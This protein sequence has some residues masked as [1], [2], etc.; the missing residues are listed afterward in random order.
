[1]A[2]LTNSMA[3]SMS[4]DKVRQV[5]LSIADQGFAVGGMF[6][7]SIALARTQTKPEYGI[8]ALTYSIF[9]FIA[10]LHNAAILEAYTI[11]GSGRYKQRFPAYSSLLW[12]RTL[13][14]TFGASLIL[15]IGWM[16]V[17]RFSPLA[18]STTVLG[19]TLTCGILLT[20]LFL[21]RT[22]Y[23]RGRPD[24][25][26]RMSVIF[27]IICA[28]LL[29]FA[30]RNAILSGFYAFAIAG[31]AWVLAFVS[32]AKE[33]PG[34]IQPGDFMS[35]EPGYWAEHWKYSRWV[36]LT[37]LVFQ[38]TTQAYYW[39][40][41]AFLSVKETGELRAIYNVIA[42]IEQVSGAIA[43]LILPMLS[44]RYA[45]RKLRGLVPLWKGYLL[46]WLCASALFAAILN[47]YSRNLMHLLYNGK[48]DELAPSLGYLAFL[49][50]LMAVGNT[51][52]AALKAM[53]R[54]KA[55]FHA[56]VASGIATI[57]GGIPLLIHFR[58]RGAVYGMLLSGSAYSVALCVIFWHSLKKERYA[59][60]SLIRGTFVSHE[61]TGA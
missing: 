50:F 1:V 3:V 13:L 36:L 26:A 60:R 27:F 47:I 45:T 17:R 25:A 38:F 42:P 61:P 8:F 49:P 22:F 21:R 33:H 2:E 48:F 52:N 30:V 58:F 43:L 28:V 19:M 46:G 39:L 56:Y 54:P 14:W 35:S 9:T 4:W 55:V 40:S 12:R 41:A 31:L 24:L 59:Q 10:G 37:A 11:Y 44:F 57:A 5:A 7:A 23:M 20:A 6:L 53:E 32:V 34:S 18:A 15:T 29:W 16:S 51:V